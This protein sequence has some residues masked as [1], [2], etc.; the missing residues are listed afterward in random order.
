MI[1]YYDVDPLF[2]ELLE[3]VIPLK[4]E[5]DGTTFVV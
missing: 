5:P 4:A 2:T 1:G 3:V